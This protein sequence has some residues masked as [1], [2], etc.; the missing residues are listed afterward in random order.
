[1]PC[2]QAQPDPI[3]EDSVGRQGQL[4]SSS[5]RTLALLSSW[6]TWGRGNMATLACVLS[7]QEWVKGT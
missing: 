2:S 1:M 4:P 7:Q 6:Q 5:E 3:A